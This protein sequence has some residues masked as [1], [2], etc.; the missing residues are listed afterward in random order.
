MLTQVATMAGLPLHALAGAPV[1][2]SLALRT[3]WQPHCAVAQGAGVL[4]RH[5]W[6]LIV[7]FAELV[8]MVFL[9][10]AS[11]GSESMLWMIRWLSVWLPALP[12]RAALLLG[13]VAHAGP[14]TFS[15]LVGVLYV[16]FL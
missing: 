15:E 9:H 16:F 13:G 1:G 11:D 4:R 7:E 2:V 6:G 8:Y 3:L 5:F 14:V 10:L 12:R